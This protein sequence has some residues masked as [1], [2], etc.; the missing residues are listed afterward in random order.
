MSADSSDILNQDVDTRRCGSVDTRNAPPT[1]RHVESH[2]T[3]MGW[4]PYGYG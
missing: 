4:G 2:S 3:G 1:G